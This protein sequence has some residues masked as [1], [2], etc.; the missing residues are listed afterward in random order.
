[1]K[2]TPQQINA[3]R[4]CY[5][6]QCTQAQAAKLMGCHRTNVTHLLKRL[7]KTNPQLFPVNGIKISIIQYRTFLDN[8]VL[9]KF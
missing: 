1:M 8:Q 7:K 9:D 6:H 4:F 3:Y 2:P 5:I